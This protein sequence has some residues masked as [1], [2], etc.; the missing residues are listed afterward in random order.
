MTL[1]DG[2]ET[3]NPTRSG[4]ES[5]YSSKYLQKS[6]TIFVRPLWLVLG[7]KLMEI[8]INLSSK[9]YNLIPDFLLVW[10]NAHSKNP[11]IRESWVVYLVVMMCHQIQKNKQLPGICDLDI[12]PYL[13]LGTRT[14]KW[15]LKPIMSHQSLKIYTP[16]KT[17]REY[18]KWWFGKCISF[19]T[20]PFWLAMLHFRGPGCIWIFPFWVP[21][22]H[23]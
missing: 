17:N 22:S 12:S 5:R 2:I 7:V 10:V 1:G 3:I 11:P 4:G 9:Y 21:N 13:T 16:T 8:N 23:I 14:D 15:V 19:Q 20:W 6:C 18:Q